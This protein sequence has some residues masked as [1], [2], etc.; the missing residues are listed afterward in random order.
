MNDEAPWTVLLSDRCECY[1]R[2]HY[3]GFASVRTQILIHRH[4]V[5]SRD[6]CPW[7]SYFAFTLA[8]DT[9]ANTSRGTT[10]TVLQTFSCICP[11]A[12]TFTTEW[13]SLVLCLIQIGIVSHL[14]AKRWE[15]AVYKTRG[16]CRSCLSKINTHDK[17]A[18]ALKW[19]ILIVCE[20]NSNTRL[21]WTD[22]DIVRLL[23]P[24]LL[25]TLAKPL[26]Y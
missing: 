7:L 8:T 22:T 11:R 4:F 25:R 1:I 23:Y 16:F 5:C 3:R 21:T 15:N 17:Y 26:Y 19:N 2:G 14:Q 9:G 10:D 13:L 6:A 12:K 24:C 20:T 18:S